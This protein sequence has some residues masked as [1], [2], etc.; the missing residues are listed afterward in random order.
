[1]KILKKQI[2]FIKRRD[3]DVQNDIKKH[4]AEH[5]EASHKWL[6]RPVSEILRQTL[7]DIPKRVRNDGGECA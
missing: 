1:M 5:R 4:H 2:N 3:S 6:K 7:N